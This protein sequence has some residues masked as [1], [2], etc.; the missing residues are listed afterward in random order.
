MKKI[1]LCLVTAVTVFSGCGSP[2]NDTETSVEH[3][4]S[5]YESVVSTESTETVDDS[6]TVNNIG[7]TDIFN[8]IISDSDSR[9]GLASVL[10][11]V[12][13]SAVCLTVSGRA[14]NYYYSYITELKAS[15]VIISE[16]GYILTANHVIEGGNS[17]TIT[18]ANGDDYT[19]ELVAGDRKSD[20]AVLKI[21]A[22]NLKA[23]PLSNSETLRIGDFIFTV[24]NSAGHIGTGAAFGFV[25]ALNT[26]V[27][28]NGDEHSVFQ[29]NACINNSNAGG[30]IFDSNGNLVGIVTANSNNNNAV[31]IA[32]AL[33]S[34]DI[35]SATEDLI[36]HG[37]VRGRPYIG[38]EAVEISSM[39]MSHMYG[40]TRLGVYVNSVHEGS[41]ASECGL[42]F[43]DYINAIDGETVISLERLEEII[44]SKKIG[45][46]IIL[47]ILR[48][49][50]TID[51][52]LVIEEEHN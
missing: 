20:V 51:M 29:I 27:S 7:E 43:K 37:Y 8:F 3:N 17:F 38:F 6:S 26:T 28:Y 45:D 40:L 18:L 15:G 41:T 24:G 14:S 30:G 42:Q 5:S 12:S 34:S 4:T 48:G 46:S 47:E 13:E 52:V 33:P 39:E 16:D 22:T 10:S 19:A 1:F 49:D 2:N 23:A 32:Y 9:A 11:T 25:S 31:G 21:D 35:A 44:S 50:N 36:N